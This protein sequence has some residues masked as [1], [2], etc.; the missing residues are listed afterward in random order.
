MKLNFNFNF[1]NNFDKLKVPLF[2]FSEQFPDI[3]LVFCFLYQNSK[4]F[5]R[6]SSQ[7]SSLEHFVSE[8]YFFWQKALAYMFIVEILFLKVSVTTKVATPSPFRSNNAN[9]TAK[10]T[11]AILRHTMTSSKR[12]FSSLESF[13]L[14][15]RPNWWRHSDAFFTWT[16]ILIR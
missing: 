10:R 13:L 2:K 6:V 14:S 3:L 7:L 5:P 16:K 1:R 4:L 8:I 15:W 9:V 11:F 12:N